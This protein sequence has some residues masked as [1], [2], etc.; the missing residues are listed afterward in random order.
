MSIG[1]ITGPFKSHADQMSIRRPTDIL[2]KS[3][4][5]SFCFFAFLFVS[6]MPLLYNVYFKDNVYV[7]PCNLVYYFMGVTWYDHWPEWLFLKGPVWFL[8]F[9]VI[10]VFI[11]NIVMYILR[12]MFTFYLVTLFI[13]LQ[14]Q[15]VNVLIKFKPKEVFNV[16]KPI[17]H[18]Y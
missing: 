16:E 2:K 3:N 7:L 12:I 13:S 1:R 4:F 5:L 8:L 9:P 11:K 6:R 15:Y 17:T 18:I 14:I 10:L